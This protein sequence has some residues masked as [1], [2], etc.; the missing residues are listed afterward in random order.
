MGKE[1][2]IDFDTLLWSSNSWSSMYVYITNFKSRIY[3][4]T[5]QKLYQKKYLLQKRLLSSPTAKI[6]AYL[7]IINAD[8]D[9]QVDIHGYNSHK[10]YNKKKCALLLEWY[11]QSQKNRDKYTHSLNTKHILL[12]ILI[13]FALEPEFN[14]KQDEAINI[15]N[16]ST[17]QFAIQ[18]VRSVIQNQEQKLYLQ[19]INLMPY[20]KTLNINYVM[21]KLNLSSALSC[22]LKSYLDKILHIDLINTSDFQKLLKYDNLSNQL[23][24]IVF[25]FLTYI[26]L[27]EVSYIVSSYNLY[28]KL[29][30][31]IH[32][33]Y[34]AVINYGYEVLIYHHRQTYVKL[35]QQVLCQIMQ[36]DK[37]SEESNKIK[38]NY[39]NNSV[40]FLGYYFVV[41]K[42]VLVSVEPCK[43]SL[44][45]LFRKINLLFLKLK[46]NSA[47]SLINSL[48]H[49]LKEWGLYFIETRAKKIFVLVDYLI[50]LKIRSWTLRKHPSWGRLKIMSKYFLVETKYLNSGIEQN[51]RLF[52]TKHIVDGKKTNYMLIRLKDL[53]K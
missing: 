26:L 43:D 3:K 11:L 31:D 35:W 4:A 5:R 32:T 30:A 9:Y 10:V 52:Y 53:N 23:S 44:I 19:N 13:L 22:I 38:E 47:I 2:N 12:V 27:S 42:N 1:I 34:I 14:A 36:S 17:P 39:V 15:V 45:L 40:N 33:S 6:C 20:L 50:Y 21:K 18:T 7:M 8:T 25:K 41:Q 16:I 48:N 29:R 37:Q 24:N 28:T 49:L 46:S 51:H